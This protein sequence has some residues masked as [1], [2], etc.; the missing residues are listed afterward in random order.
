MMPERPIN[1]P[2]IAFTIFG[3]IGLVFFAL[4]SLLNPAALLPAGSQI[5][6]AATTFAQYQASRNLAVALMLALVLMRRQA[7]V[8]GV[9][10]THGRNYPSF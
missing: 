2:I 5:N 7:K 4:A 1:K 10:F 9:L 8:L 6:S 3:G